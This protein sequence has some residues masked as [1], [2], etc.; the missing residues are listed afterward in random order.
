MRGWSGAWLGCNWGWAPTFF[1]VLTSCRHMSAITC[2][3][4]RPTTRVGAAR[5]GTGTDR[6]DETSDRNHRSNRGHTSATT[7]QGDNVTARQDHFNIDAATIAIIARSSSRHT[8]PHTHT[9]PMEGCDTVQQA[10]DPTDLGMD[11]GEVR[12]EDQSSSQSN[13]ARS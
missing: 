6:T 10:T 8:R 9:R 5:A 3:K 13:N 11:C 4:K 12:S 1:L 2:R 7:K